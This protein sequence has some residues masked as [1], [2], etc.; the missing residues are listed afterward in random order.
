MSNSPIT[1][2][3]QQ[4]RKVAMLVAMFAFSR[5]S[6]AV[7]SSAAEAAPATAAPAEQPQ[8][9]EPFSPPGSMGNY[10]TERVPEM[11][12]VNVPPVRIFFPPVPPTIGMPIERMS[13]VRLGEPMAPAELSAYINEVFYAPL[14]SLLL[15]N[16]VSARMRR[17]LEAYRASRDQLTSELQVELTRL[18]N[19]DADTRQRG[20]LA[21]AGQ[22]APKLVQLE[23]TAE[24][25]RADLNDV[26]YGWFVQREWH[27]GGYRKGGFSASEISEVMCA[28]AFYHSGLNP[29]QRGL[30]REISLEI[31]M[32]ANETGDGVQPGGYFSPAMARVE[33]PDDLP[34]AIAGRIETYRERKAALKQ[35]LYDAVFAQEKAHFLR[36]NILKNRVSGQAPYLTELEKLADEIRRDLAAVPGLMTPRV[37]SPLPPQLTA[38]VAALAESRT[39]LRVETQADIDA[40]YRETKNAQGP[41]VL[42]YEFT[43]R[44]LVFE[45]SFKPSRNP[46]FVLAQETLKKMETA[47]LALASLADSYRRRLAELDEDETSVRRE[48]TDSLTQAGDPSPEAALSQSLRAALGEG[49]PGYRDYRIAVFEPGLSAEQR[50]L[51]FGSALR[52]L[53]LPLPAGDLQPTKLR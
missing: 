39:A 25:L 23:A 38:R 34:A 5:V 26:F 3:G 37:E 4:H 32:T 48:I 15:K 18:R 35:E 52:E 6:P 30:L 10:N 42:N 47:T 12:G 11:P 22:Q 51:L 49:T 46:R 45:V 8:P 27:L 13:L 43:D 7:E 19:A 20:L 16:E 50:R 28:Y 41:I 33:F 31:L 24:Q 2:F 40:I 53:Q 14:S 17:R 21:F 9:S 1:R 29:V 44:G 36:G